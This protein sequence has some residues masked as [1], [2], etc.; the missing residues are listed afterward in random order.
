ML[1]GDAA[2][3]FYLIIAIVPLLCVR[4]H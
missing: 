1:Q 3:E 4:Q 2:G